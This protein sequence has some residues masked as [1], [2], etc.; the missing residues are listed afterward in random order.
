MEHET[1]KHYFMAQVK[2]LVEVLE[3]IGAVRESP[4]N[5]VT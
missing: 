3:L 1:V 4:P 5:I 2:V